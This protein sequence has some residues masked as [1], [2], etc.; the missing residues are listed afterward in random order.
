[1]NAA[2]HPLE[3]FEADVQ[4]NE[5]LLRTLMPGADWRWLRYPYLSEGA[6]PQRPQ[7]RSFLADEGYRVAGVTMSF[8]D[9][10]FNEPYARCVAK[11][12]KQSVGELERD[13]LSAAQDSLRFSR[14]MAHDL[15]GHDI[16]Y[17]LLM[18]V[19]AF[20]A[21]MLTRLLSFYHARGVELVSLAE[22]Q[23]DP[24]YQQYTDLRQAPGPSSLEA[25]MSERQLALPP[26]TDY[27]RKLE[28]MCR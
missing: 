22:A 2:Q 28:A 18:H 14:A 8:S 15:Y 13:Y 4:R 25:A 26:R 5:P 23:S 3:D 10:L 21:R 17:V 12:D 16:P 9:Y 19:G 20:D 1:M 27:S 7:L 24:W 6:A 11:A